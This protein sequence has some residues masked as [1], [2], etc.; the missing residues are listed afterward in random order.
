MS[1]IYNITVQRPDG[2]SLS[3]ENYQGNVLL[4]VNTATECGLA[5]Q[6]KPLEKL[7]QE[8]KDD[9]FVVLGFPC[10]QFGDQEPVSDDE[11]VSTCEINFGVTFPLFKKIDVNGKDAHPLFDYL[12]KSL[13]GLLTNNIK[14]NFTKFLVDQEG[15]PVKRFAPTDHPSVIRRHV[16]KLLERSEK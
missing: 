6:Y 13:P 2:K 8:F 14:W 9:G 4:I 16:E 3:L 12:K 11:M 7:Y 10:N 1:E 15:N 5:T